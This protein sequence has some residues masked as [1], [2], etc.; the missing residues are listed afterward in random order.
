MDYEAAFKVTA[1]AAVVLVVGVWSFRGNQVERLEEEVAEAREETEQTS[2]LHGEEVSALSETNAACREAVESGRRVA[3]SAVRA[4]LA[5]YDDAQEWVRQAYF[6]G[7]RRDLA[8]A[9]QGLS[10]MIAE[11]EAFYRGL[12]AQDLAG[13]DGYGWADPGSTGEENPA[14]VCL[15]IEE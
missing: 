14:R 2:E 4:H 3:R 7:V 9:E 6:L 10:R 1:I 12:P 13:N 15:G 8:E 11:K 5:L